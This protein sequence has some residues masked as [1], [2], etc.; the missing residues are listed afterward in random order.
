MYLLVTALL[1]TILI[2]CVLA[3]STMNVGS[4]ETAEHIPSDCEA[5]TLKQW[6]NFG[7]GILKPA[8]FTTTAVTCSYLMTYIIENKG[9]FTIDSFWVL[10]RRGMCVPRRPSV[11]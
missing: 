6:Q 7:R 11:L 9:L 8:K 2:I 10:V 4:V 3:A 5:I 1:V